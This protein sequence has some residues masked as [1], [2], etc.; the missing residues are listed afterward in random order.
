MQLGW[1]P[2]VERIHEGNEIQYKYKICDQF[3][4]T[5][6]PLATYGADAMVSRGTRVYEARD[7]DGN[8]VAIKDS[9]R[10]EDRDPEGAILGKVLDDVRGK[11]GEEAAAEAKKYFIPVRI[12][13]DV[14]VCGKS[15]K[16]FE[17][18]EEDGNSN[19]KW[20]YIEVDP[21]LSDRRHILDSEHLPTV[22]TRR[23]TTACFVARLPSQRRRSS[24]ATACIRESISVKES[25]PRVVLF[26][27][28]TDSLLQ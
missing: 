17:L 4:T 22:K 1:D 11:L 9:W 20:I 26:N 12:Y 15:D 5:T 2:T 25:T 27:S 18:R 14:V 19:L 23:T 3:F 7:A 24:D 21:I 16:T 6:R 10:D 28:C 8:I 13:E